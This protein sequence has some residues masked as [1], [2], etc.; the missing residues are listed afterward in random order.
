M[1]NEG[2][3]LLVAQLFAAAGRDYGETHLVVYRK[4]LENVSDDVGARAVD[5]LIRHVS[6]ERP[7]SVGLVLD[8]VQA[9]LRARQ[10]SIPAIEEATGEPVT[11][12]QALAWVAYIRK[13]KGPSKWADAM[14]DVARRQP[15]GDDEPAGPTAGVGEGERPGLAAP[16]TQGQAGEG[17]GIT[18]EPTEGNQG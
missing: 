6:W 15:K 17:T 12:A 4:A 2:V 1:T 3:A 7:P 13:T 5:S 9:E 18:P 8:A 14:E 16:D 11:R 10:E